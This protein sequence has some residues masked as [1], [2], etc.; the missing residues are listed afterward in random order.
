MTDVC[1]G[2]GHVLQLTAFSFHMA[3]TDVLLHGYVVL[4][5]WVIDCLTL[6]VGGGLGMW[7]FR[8]DVAIT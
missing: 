1:I 4:N 3:P 5:I 6:T 2:E 8:A 7:R